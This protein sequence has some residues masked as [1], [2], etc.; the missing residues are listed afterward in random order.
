MPW[1]C[2]DCRGRTRWCTWCKVRHCACR[3]HVSRKP[4]YLYKVHVIKRADGRHRT[5]AAR[6][7]AHLKGAQKGGQKTALGP[8]P[9]RFDSEAAR[10]ASRR[11]WDR[12]CKPNAISGIRR[13][14][15]SKRTRP[16]VNRR[17]LRALYSRAPRLGIRYLPVTEQW[18]H[19]QDCGQFIIS[20]RTALRRLGHLLYPRK[21]WVPA[22]NEVIVATTT[23]TDPAVRRARRRQT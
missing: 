11:R 6:R 1:Y 7:Y 18:I 2:A 12:H 23:G 5:M 13:G 21:N 9:G 15:P 4:Q 3:P 17:L 16:E 8:N 22:E 19:V 10:A 20:E 14:M